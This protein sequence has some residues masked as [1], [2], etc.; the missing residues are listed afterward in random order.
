MQP[1]M[2]TDTDWRISFALAKSMKA[3]GEGFPP[4]A[5]KNK[6]RAV[7]IEVKRNAGL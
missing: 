6:S 7:V 4:G 3:G 2:L 1:Q 5:I